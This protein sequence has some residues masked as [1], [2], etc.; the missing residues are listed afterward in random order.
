MR[1]RQRRSSAIGQLVK[2]IDPNEADR[3]QW[4][5]FVIVGRKYNSKRYRSLLAYPEETSWYFG[6]KAIEQTPQTSS[7]IWVSEE[8]LCAFAG[9]KNVNIAGEF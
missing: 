9:A 1:S 5:T 4:K 8:W 6:L 3:S 2:I 7:E